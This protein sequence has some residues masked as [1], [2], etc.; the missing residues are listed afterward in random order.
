L[1]LVLALAL[2]WGCSPARYR[3][4]ADREAYRIIREKSPAVPG[5]DPEF[6]IEAA[7]PPVSLDGAPEVTEADPALGPDGGGEV[8]ARILS[9]ERA[10][11]LAVTNSRSYQNEK[12]ALYLEA[13]GLTLD[14]HRYTPI[15]SGG[16]STTFTQETREVTGASDFSRVLGAAGDVIGEIEQLTG[17]PADLLNQYASIVE[18]AGAIAGWDNPQTD[19]VDERTLTGDSSFGV[20]ILLKGGGQ[21]ALG[22]TSNFL[23]FL[24]GDARESAN[25]VLT[26]SFA[27]P[28]LR[29]AGS[30]VSAE[31][32]TQAERNVLY[33]LREFTRFR[34]EFTVDICSAY[35]GVLEQRD[36]VRNNYRSY[37]NFQR[38]FARESAFAQEGRKTQADLG[39]LEQSLLTNEDS[40][41]NSIRQYKENLDR[42]KV[43]IGLSTDARVVLDDQE[44]DLLRSSGL[45]H[46]DISAEDAVKVALTTRLDL[47]NEHDRLEDSERRVVVAANALKPGL[48]LLLQGSVRNTGETD[49][50][51]LDF[52]Q[53]RWNAGVDLDLPLDRKA[54]RN[55][56]R[57]ALIAHERAMRGLTLAEDNI[58]LQV[59]ADWR[60]LDQARRNYEVAKKKVE[61]NERRVEEQDLRAELGQVTVLDLVDAQN[62]LTESQ[63]GLTAALVNH[64]LFRLGFWRDMGILYIKKDGRWEEVTDAYGK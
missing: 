23:R 46:P 56:Y 12:E 10:L 39:R 61:L 5:M 31:R 41:I 27:Q 60:N 4:R 40:W 6:S 18:Q 21:I 42:F 48:D 35:Y 15:F 52:R 51:D 64:T 47:Y 58:K 9:L 57:S 1:A 38:S 63:N 45:S 20:G 50:D 59:R 44:L 32:L 8:G 25:S 16:A 24:T 19:L 34:Q 43:Q 30:K 7:A 28:L 26:G 13:L 62:A 49:F 22:L 36:A 54:E 29:G 17:T 14:R 37:V 55:G 3:D 11:Q 53:G 2:T 33:S